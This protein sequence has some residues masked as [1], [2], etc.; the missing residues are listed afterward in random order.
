M[1]GSREALD[2]AAADQRRADIG[3]RVSQR[4]DG[5]QSGLLKAA[6]RGKVRYCGKSL[7]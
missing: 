6:L 4:L 1:S 3:Y 5:I 2:A 7:L